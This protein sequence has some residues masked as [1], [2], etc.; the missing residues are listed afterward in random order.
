MAPQTAIFPLAS[1]KE[2]HRPDLM[3]H[4]GRLDLSPGNTVEVAVASVVMGAMK[5]APYVPGSRS[6]PGLRR[7]KTTIS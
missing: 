7:A 1:V 3:S 5:I 4:T 6:R 2:C